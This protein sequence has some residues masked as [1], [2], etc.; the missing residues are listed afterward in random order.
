MKKLCFI[1]LFILGSAIYTDC[2]SQIGGR[3][4]EKR[5]KTKKRG[6]HILTQYKSHGHADKF[7]K[8]NNGRRGRL[9]RLFRK[10]Q[11]SW[12]YKSSGSKRSA[13]R[14]NQYLLT[15]SRSSGKIDN[16]DVLDRQN[17]KRSKSRVKGNRIFRFKKYKSR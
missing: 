8:G 3:K 13:F 10:K 14:A 6:N 12:V 4:T 15:R 17:G 2:Y 7:A 5:I 11:P 16:A 9:A 1:L